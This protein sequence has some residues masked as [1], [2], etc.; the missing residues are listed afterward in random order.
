MRVLRIIKDLWNAESIH[1]R[2]SIP[3]YFSQ[4]NTPGVQE[5]HKMYGR[6]HV[7]EELIMDL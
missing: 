2:D 3:Y 1:M 5:L 4:L 7:F 6:N